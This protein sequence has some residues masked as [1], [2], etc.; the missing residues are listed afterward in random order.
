MV[1][2]KLKDFNSLP[3]QLGLGLIQTIVDLEQFIIIQKNAQA[4]GFGA[5]TQSET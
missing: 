1:L 4:D 2:G 3:G 5:N